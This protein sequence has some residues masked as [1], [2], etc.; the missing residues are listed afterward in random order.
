MRLAALTLTFIFV[1]S[2]QDRAVGQDEIPSS[3]FSPQ[4]I[5]ERAIEAFEG[6][7][8]T[9]KK[10]ARDNLKRT[11]QL[12]VSYLVGGLNTASEDAVCWIIKALAEI[13][14]DE[15][16]SAVFETA[17]NGRSTEQIAA[18]SAMSAF[19]DPET[20]TVLV[21]LADSTDGKIRLRA[22]QNLARMETKEALPH[23][24]AALQDDSIKIAFAARMGISSLAKKKIVSGAAEQ[25]I[26]S[27]QSTGETPDEN[28]LRLLG[29]LRDGAAVG[30]LTELFESPD[31]KI[32]LTAVW[33][34]GKI[35][36][37]QAIKFLV[38]R[39]GRIRKNEELRLAVIE[40]MGGSTDKRDRY[41]IPELIDLI[42][43]EK[44]SEE[45]LMAAVKSLGKLTRMNFGRNPIR[46]VDWWD[47]ELYDL[48]EDRNS[49]YI[50]AHN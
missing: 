35:G 37:K 9:E 25:V 23:L 16:R 34:L 43:D 20:V 8:W 19:K 13:G 18:I 27:W 22:V 42:T 3:R 44:E 7:S 38:R 46:W 17:R 1:A 4:E 41:V 40:A 32:A 15:A 24:A 39:L 48:P 45:I 6:D 12:G 10:E 11:G 31:K 49:L 33:A 2:L 50:D 36:N 47:R 14:G 29:E 21:E 28:S 30:Y 26:A 5:V